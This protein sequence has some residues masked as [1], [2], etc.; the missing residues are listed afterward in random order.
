MGEQ[1][2]GGFTAIQTVSAGTL[3]PK[4]VKRLV[5]G[6][7]VIGQYNALGQRVR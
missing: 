1:L 3:A 4:P 6:Q 7:I 5:R 2:Q